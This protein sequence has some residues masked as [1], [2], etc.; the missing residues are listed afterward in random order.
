[1][2][3]TTPAESLEDVRLFFN[4]FSRENFERH[5]KEDRLLA[6]RMRLIEQYARIQAQETI[7]D[8]GCGNGNHL[9]A[10]DGLFEVG[11]GVDLSEG[12]IDAA[13]IAKPAN[14]RSH[15]RFFTDDAH[16]LVNQAGDSVDVV[17]CIGALE[18]MPN[19]PAVLQSVHRVLKR[20]GR[21]VCLTL[22]DEFV[23]YSK[24]APAFG[25]AT[26]HLASDRRLNT[27]EAL[28]L[29]EN[30]GFHSIRVDYWSFTPRGDMPVAFAYLC[31]MLEVVG[32]FVAPRYL[33]GG[34]VLYGEAK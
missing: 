10:L 5:G 32:R 18:H 22:N 15:Y 2:L 19:K 28:A 7:L 25:L 13:R 11:I 14:A 23:W 4:R 12:M 26:Q 29:L 27:N 33:R 6:Y 20:R 34:L 1:M 9:F 17:I 8:L 24:L 21:F 16:S 30:A 3:Q 31:R